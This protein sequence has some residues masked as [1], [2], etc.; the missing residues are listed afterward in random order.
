MLRLLHT[1]RDL[2]CTEGALDLLSIYEFRTCPALWST[3][4]DHRP[5][6]TFRILLVSRV[7][8]D[9]LDLLDDGVHGFC[10][11]LVHGHRIITLNKVRLPA[12]ALEEGLNLVMRNTGENS[13]V[14][15][16]ISV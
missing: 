1:D 12:T 11:L 4:N 7:F 16:L 2:M 15:D 13:R 10:H 9:G 3:Q 5:L 8:L 6:R 14:A